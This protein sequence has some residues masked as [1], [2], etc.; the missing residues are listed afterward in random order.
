MLPMQAKNRNT[1]GAKGDASSMAMPAS[2]QKPPDGMA[3]DAQLV[4]QANPQ[5]LMCLA[6]EKFS[7][8]EAD[9]KISKLSCHI[10]EPLSLVAVGGWQTYPRC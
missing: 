1:D 6:S 8:W 10:A 9:T 2:R 7:G 5:K 3:D 4:E